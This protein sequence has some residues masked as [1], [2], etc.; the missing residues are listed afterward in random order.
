MS[1]WS[2]WVRWTGPDAPSSPTAR[3]PALGD[4]SILAPLEFPEF[5]TRE[6]PELTLRLDEDGALLIY[7]TVDTDSPIVVNLARMA[8]RLPHPADREQR[9]EAYEQWLVVLRQILE[10]R[11]VAQDW[12]ERLLVRLVT[13]EWVAGSTGETDLVVREV[14]GLGLF[15]ALVF[16][17]PTSVRFVT[18]TDLQK[19]GLSEDEAHA[20]AFANFRGR[21][22][23]SV[24]RDQL[25]EPKVT[26]YMA[27]DSYE[28]AR[29]L[30]IPDL[31]EPGEEIGVAIPDR[32]SLV[33]FPLGTG[34]DVVR[35]LAESDSPD[36]L[37][38]CGVRVTRDGFEP[39]G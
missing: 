13:P 23:A 38:D 39:L 14:D 26:R 10:G 2:W 27:M 25:R 4:P 12:A 17:F 31:L 9:E 34:E 3:T 20:R 1:W 30:L 21:L 37:L 16:D 7:P 33:L 11:D 6:H 22:P 36:A 24:V 19:L 15:C 29:I 8:S 5:I 35:Q 28:A 18:T 32:D